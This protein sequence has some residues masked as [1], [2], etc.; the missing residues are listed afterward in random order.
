MS[1]LGEH[2][3]LVRWGFFEQH[4]VLVRKVWVHW[5]FLVEHLVSV[6]VHHLVLVRWGFLE[7]QLVVV[8]ALAPTERLLLID[9]RWI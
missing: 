6:L 2:L 9:R 3:V 5:G 4:L 7:K 8:L 1:V